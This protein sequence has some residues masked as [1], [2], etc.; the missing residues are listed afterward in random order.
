LEASNLPLLTSDRPLHQLHGLGDPDILITLP[1]GPR[2]LFVAARRLET[3]R[4]LTQASPRKLVME[5]NRVTVGL[6]RRYVWAADRAQTAFIAQG[7]GAVSAP[8]LGEQLS[9]QTSHM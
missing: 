6:A 5:R 7:M 4:R 1:I 8:S 2:R 9:R 3:L